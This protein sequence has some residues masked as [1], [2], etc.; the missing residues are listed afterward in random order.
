MLTQQTTTR[1]NHPGRTW[2]AALTLA[3]TAALGACG[4]GEE[5]VTQELSVQQQREAAALQRAHQLNADAMGKI[6]NERAV[7][8]SQPN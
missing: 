1:T 2:M 5:A 4:A 7:Q 6:K 8:R 3:A